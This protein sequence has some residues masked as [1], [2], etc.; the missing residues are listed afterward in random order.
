MLT[1]EFEGYGEISARVQEMVEEH[2]RQRIAEIV[3]SEVGNITVRLVATES[4]G[5]RYEIRGPAHLARRIEQ[6]L[7]E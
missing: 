4:D 7:S 3:R 6:A 2:L 1:V 5:V